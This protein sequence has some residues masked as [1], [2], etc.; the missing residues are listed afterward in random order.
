MSVPCW[1]L[2]RWTI[3]MI[4]FYRCTVE[5]HHISSW[6]MS[7]KAPLVPSALGVWRRQN[8]H[9][10]ASSSDLITRRIILRIYHYYITTTFGKEFL[11]SDYARSVHW[12][13]RPWL[14][15]GE[16]ATTWKEIY[17][18]AIVTTGS[19]TRLISGREPASVSLVIHRIHRNNHNVQ[20]CLSQ[21]P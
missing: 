7:H 5:I 21:P 17:R 20:P 4:S 12:E 16:M 19:W 9:H 6:E 2:T 13:L 8:V 1:N 15:D 18:P 10:I 14:T 11:R 3:L